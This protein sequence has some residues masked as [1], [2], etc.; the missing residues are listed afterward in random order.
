SSEPIEIKNAKY[1][2]KKL[3]KSDKNILSKSDLLRLCRT[4]RA[5]E[6]DV[7][8]EILEDMNCI[9]IEIIKNSER[10]KPKEVIKINPLIRK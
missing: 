5:Y 8:L 10:G 7:P 2:L 1:I 4:L 9:K 6:F 3:K